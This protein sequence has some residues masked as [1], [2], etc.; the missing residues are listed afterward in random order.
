[1]NPLNDVNIKV[2]ILCVL[3]LA[4]TFGTEAW[5]WRWMSRI[6][7]FTRVP[8]LLFG[9]ATLAYWFWHYE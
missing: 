6:L 7:N 5:A 4:F 3:W 1:M 2:T 9:L 8:V